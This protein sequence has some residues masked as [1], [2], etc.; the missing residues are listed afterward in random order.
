MD[1][2]K[3]ENNMLRFVRIGAIVKM[4]KL[5]RGAS[6]FMQKNSSVS[7]TLRLVEYFNEGVT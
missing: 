4:G 6:Q 1:E 5:A 7:C 3:I 2:T